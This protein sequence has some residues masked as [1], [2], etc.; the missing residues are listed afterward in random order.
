MKDQLLHY[1][2]HRGQTRVLLDQWP[3]FGCDKVT[4]KKHEATRPLIIYDGR[5]KE[6]EK[7]TLH[8]GDNTFCAPA[9]YLPTMDT[10]RQLSSEFAAFVQLIYTYNVIS[11]V[12]DCTFG[13][14]CSA[15][16]PIIFFSYK[17]VIGS[18]SYY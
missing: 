5:G 2:C 8:Q 11:D 16:R 17:F 12:L 3:S 14:N 7:L 18:F 1:L 15:I 10:I 13:H 9:E 6:N 4:A